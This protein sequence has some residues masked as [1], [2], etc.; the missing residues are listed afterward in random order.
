MELRHYEDG[1]RMISG[2]RQN[3]DILFGANERKVMLSYGRNPQK[4]ESDSDYNKREAIERNEFEA[5]RPMPRHHV[6][7]TSKELFEEHKKVLRGEYWD[8]SPEDL[9][10]EA[11]VLAN[12]YAAARQAQIEVPQPNIPQKWKEQ[13][14]QDIKDE[15]DRLDKLRGFIRENKYEKL[16]EQLAKMMEKNSIDEPHSSV[17]VE[18]EV[19]GNDGF[20]VRSMMK[21][22]QAAVHRYKNFDQ[23]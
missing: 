3:Q 9:T 6:S 19:D 7:F 17:N 14:Q 4:W 18:S 15:N 13:N 10:K 20:D 16:T 2:W 1:L 12:M 5:L 8:S 23:A 21:T 11:F 22:I